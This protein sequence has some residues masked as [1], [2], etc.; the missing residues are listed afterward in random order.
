MPL[1]RFYYLFHTE[2]RIAALVSLNARNG[3]APPRIRTHGTWERCCFPSY[4]NSPVDLASIGQVQ[5]GRIIDDMNPAN[6]VIAPSQ[7]ER[8]K[9][10]FLIDDH[11]MHP[12]S[13]SPVDEASL[14][15]SFALWGTDQNAN[16]RVVVQC[17]FGSVDDFRIPVAECKRLQRSHRDHKT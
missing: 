6:E 7:L 16:L 5:P 17:V 10:K 9:L 8:S 13:D 1:V 4:N 14:D 11:S 2:V 15:I 12:D 3:V